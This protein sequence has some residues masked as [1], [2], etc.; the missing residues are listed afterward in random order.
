ML[1]SE[2]NAKLG[3]F[4]VARTIQDKG[5]THHS[6]LEIAGTLGYMAPETFLISKATVETEVYSFGV[7]L[8]EV[9]CGR[10]PGKQNEEDTYN[11]SIV[12][13]IWDL[14]KKGRIV[15]VADPRMEGK[16]EKE[17]ME[18]VLI[19]GLACCHPNPNYR[20]SMKIVLQVL[21]GEVEPPPVPLEWPSF[22]WLVMPPSFS[23]L[24]NSTTG[25]LLAPF[26]ELT[27]R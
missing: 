23:K 19:L 10:K 11:S 22:V 16:F 20:R 15:D 27:G 24:E 25:S 8:L 13:W 4:G 12:N 7:L 2:F 1:D 5:K 21:T 14:H 17:E 6:T 9:V 26:S 3:D 18:C